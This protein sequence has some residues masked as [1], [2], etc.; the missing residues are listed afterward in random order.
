VKKLQKPNIAKE[1][2][3]RIKANLHDIKQKWGE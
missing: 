2:A 1:Y 3:E